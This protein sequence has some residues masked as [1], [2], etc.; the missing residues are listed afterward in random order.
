MLP[1]YISRATDYIIFPRIL[2]SRSRRPSNLDLTTWKRPMECRERS[3]QHSDKSKRTISYATEDCHTRPGIQDK[4]T[5]SRSRLQRRQRSADYSINSQRQRHIKTLG[6]AGFRAASSL[7]A[8]RL[9]GG[10]EHHSH[11]SGITC[12]WAKANDGRYHHNLTQNG[13]PIPRA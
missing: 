3:A 12:I 1:S 5:K 7:C 6:T 13:G 11:P 2:S 8:N 4:H 10:L 9:L